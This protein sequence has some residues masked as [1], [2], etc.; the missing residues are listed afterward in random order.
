M[1][2]QEEAKTVT[3]YE[4]GLINDDGST[5]KNKAKE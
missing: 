4:T 3:L 2:E 1:N 5:S